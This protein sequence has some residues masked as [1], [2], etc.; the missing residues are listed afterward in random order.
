MA[1]WTLEYG[2]NAGGKTKLYEL[3]DGGTVTAVK[4]GRRRLGGLNGPEGA[5]SV[6]A[7]VSS[8]ER[9]ARS[10]HRANIGRLPR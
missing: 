8:C 4:I 7:G 1:N 5:C 10:D 2:G 9:R 6:G 3:I